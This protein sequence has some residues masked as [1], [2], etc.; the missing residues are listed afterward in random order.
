[1]T[2]AEARFQLAVIPL[3]LRQPT[4]DAAVVEV[5]ATLSPP[6]RL[7]LTFYYQAA[8]YLQCLERDQLAADHP[9]RDHFS[10]ELSLPAAS[11]VADQP[12]QLERALLDTARLQARAT[13]LDLN[14]AEAYWTA[15]RFALRKARHA[16]A[17]D[18]SQPSH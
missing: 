14:W 3:L 7:T 17:P 9:L 15:A 2:S 16:A 18:R 13:G 6:Q 10:A 11:H 1:M 8:T 4:C 12:G 5:L